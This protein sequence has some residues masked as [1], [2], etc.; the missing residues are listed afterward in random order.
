MISE[1]LI[2]WFEN[3]HRKMP[4][5]ETKDAYTIWLSE[6]I[7]QQTQV[8]QGQP[9]FEKFI[10]KYPTIEHLAQANEDEVLKL[11]QGL[12][13]Y[14]RARNLLFNA[15]Y[16]CQNLKAQFPKTYHEL[17]QLKGVGEYTAAAI[18]SFAYDEAEA[19]VDGNVIRVISRLFMV[20]LPYNKADGKKLIK[21]LAY[22]IL[23][24]L[25]PAKHNQ[26]M[27]ELGATICKPTN[28][29]CDKCPVQMHCLAFIDKSMLSYPLKIEKKKSKQLYFNFIVPILPNGHTLIIKRTEP[30]IWKNL[31][32]FI[33][34]ESSDTLDEKK[35]F[36]LLNF[37]F[38]DFKLLSHRSLKHILTHRIIQANFYLIELKENVEFKKNNIFEVELESLEKKYSLPR[39]ITKYLERKDIRDILSSYDGK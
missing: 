25:N 5:R 38:S 26:A 3:N 20:D 15:K 8:I 16:I 13:Y 9:Y 18:A 34:H 17:I 33:M 35:A 30:G 32:S 22:Q 36:E 21:Q 27:M 1:R 28:P 7:L 14:S 6:I 23:D 12:G 11:W 2:N 29:M 4:W 31:Y 24:T 10:A 19:V 39:I 37:E